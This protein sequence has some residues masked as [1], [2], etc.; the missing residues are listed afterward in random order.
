MGIY[1]EGNHQYPDVLINTCVV[2]DKEANEYFV[3]ATT[4]VHANASKVIRIYELRTEIEEDFRQLKDF[5]KLE[6]FKSTKY[7]VIAFH[8]VCVMLGYL[9]YQ[10]YIN[11]ECGHKY[12]DKSL[13]A[14]MKRYESKLLSHFV[15][16]GGEY[17]CCM[18][19][20]EFFEFRDSCSVE[21]KKYLLE[22]FK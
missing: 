11:S 9:F 1:W 20:I 14:I 18:S 17:F 22:F 19:M 8:I 3:F 2:W 7:N 10:I 5:W 16:Y 15:L 4:D 6:D 21:V 12:F 13:P